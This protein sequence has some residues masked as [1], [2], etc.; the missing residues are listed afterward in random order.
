M[1]TANSR[2]PSA[3]NASGRTEPLSNSVYDPA[4]TGA[5]ERSSRAGKRRISER[6]IAD[7]IDQMEGFGRAS[8]NGRDLRKDFNTEARR[9]G[10]NL[11]EDER[12]RWAPPCRPSGNLFESAPCQALQPIIFSSTE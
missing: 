5:V 2:V 4:L 11:L 8:P 1:F 3:D 9:H 12:L 10:E 6:P 7:A